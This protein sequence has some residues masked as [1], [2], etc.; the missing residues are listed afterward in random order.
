VKEVQEK[1][2]NKK[3]RK[4]IKKFHYSFWLFILPCALLFL[5]FF[6]VPLALNFFYSFTDYDGFRQ[7][8]QIGFANYQELF[9]DRE[10]YQTLRRTFIYTFISLPFKVI[11]PLGLAV[12]MVSKV[13]RFKT[14][15]RGLIYLPVLLSSLV[16][17]LT[18]NWMFGEQYGLVNFLLEQLGFAR[19]QWATNPFFTKML[20]IIA[21]TWASTGFYMLIYI[22]ALSGIDEEIDE[23]ALLDGAT[24]WKKFFHIIVP[25]IKPTTFLVS[26]LSII[27]LLKEYAL[28]QGITQ[29]GPGT[30]T[31]YIVQYI[32]SEGFDKARYGYA[33]AASVIVMIIF[34]AIAFVQFRFSRGGEVNG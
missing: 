27:S 29:G 18:M 31:T 9:Q 15:T 8:N 7:M 20:I 16:V 25:L 10:F 13:V 23:A 12:L 14:L 2:V 1:Q 28:I 5:L 21:S 34:A 17:G 22:G 11:L 6:I 4:Q 24:G 19:V 3:K 26:L 30:S 32:L 33:S